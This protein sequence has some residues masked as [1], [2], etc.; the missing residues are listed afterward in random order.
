MASAQLTRND[1]GELSRA[2]KAALR[3]AG[4][5]ERINSPELLIAALRFYVARLDRHVENRPG[6]YQDA[7]E[8]IKASSK[9]DRRT[10]A[11]LR[12]AR[13]VLGV[14]TRRYPPQL[15]LAKDYRWRLKRYARIDLDDLEVEREFLALPADLTI[16]AEVE[17]FAASN[18]FLLGVVRNWLTGSTLGFP[19]QSAKEPEP[20]ERE[21]PEPTWP[22]RFHP[23]KALT[24]NPWAEVADQVKHAKEQ[25]LARLEQERSG[26]GPG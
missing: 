8:L 3:N 13:R 6:Q 14:F 12:A 16:N 20:E 18:P 25:A 26:W 24:S 21:E 15:R 22:S 5:A 11:H 9:L 17:Q 10:R 23:P 1:R 19:A 2:E 4:L 7:E